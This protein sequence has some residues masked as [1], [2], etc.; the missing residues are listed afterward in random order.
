MAAPAAGFPTPAPMIAPAAAPKTVPTAPLVTALL[1]AASA[2]SMPIW[3]R[4]YWRHITSS[5]WKTSKGF[6]GAGNT[7]TFGPVGMTTQPLSTPIPSSTIPHFTHIPNSPHYGAVKT[8]DLHAP[9]PCSTCGP[10][11][12]IRP[13]LAHILQHAMVLCPFLYQGNVTLD[14]EHLDSPLRH[15]KSLIVSTAAIVC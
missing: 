9:P 12:P 8:P 7:I 11:P 1:F 13:S 2:G 3:D 5:P 14:H 6:P 4:A 10:L 15:G